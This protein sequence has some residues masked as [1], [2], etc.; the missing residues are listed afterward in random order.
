MDRNQI[1]GM[2]LLVVL[3]TLYMFNNTNEQKKLQAQK[4]KTEQISQSQSDT[5]TDTTS[6]EASTEAKSATDSS[7]LAALPEAKAQDIVLQNNLLELTFSTLGASAKKAYLKEYKTFWGA[8]LILFDGDDNYVD[9]TIPFQNQIVHTKDLHFTPKVTDNQVVF[10]SPVGE[11]SLS[12]TYTLRPDEYMLD[13]VVK[14]NGQVINNPLAI[15][16]QNRSLHTEQDLK[17][18]RTNSHFYYQEWEDQSVDFYNVQEK[19]EEEFDEKMKWL[20]IK[21]SFFNS[22]IISKDAGFDDVKSLS[23]YDNEDS[24]YVS[25]TLVSFTLDKTPDNT[26]EF[27]YFLGPNN[28]DL[29][30]TYQL[31]LEKIVPMGRGIFAFVKYINRG[32]ILPIFEFLSKFI[33]N[34]GIIIMIL[35]LFIRILLSFF[36]YKSYLSQAKMQALKPELDEIR[37]KYK[38]DQQKLGSEQMKLYSQAGVNPLGGCLP[39]LFQLPFLIAMYSFF[40]SSL[41]LRQQGFLWCQDLSTYDSIASWST[42]IPVLSSLYGNHISLFTILLTITSLF[43]ALYNSSMTADQNNPALKY[44]P[45]VMPVMFLGFFNNMAAGLT[46]YY[47]FSNCI[48]IVQQWVIKNYVIDKDKIRSQIEENKKKPATQSKFA[49]KLAEMQKENELRKQQGKKKKK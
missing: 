48:S 42:H 32:I 12:I 36:T 31:G 41:E 39:S 19:K 22:T 7:M 38:D 14:L 47:F 21:P 30:K 13:G 40:P 28:Y 15:E 3:L 44:L 37:E 43:L 23:S 26:Y 1:I 5:S 9:F 2:G 34:Y 8:P 16:W 27:Q 33:S 18:E 11:N 10:T 25:T 6:T 4:A 49:Q 35:T 20:S 29:L 24:S 45:Y 17:N 46:F